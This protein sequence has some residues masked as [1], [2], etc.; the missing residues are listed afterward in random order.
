MLFDRFYMTEQCSC[1]RLSHELNKKMA[2]ISRAVRVL[3]PVAHRLSRSFD[4]AVFYEK[5]VPDIPDTLLAL[6]RNYCDALG[7]TDAAFTSIL[8]QLS[9]LV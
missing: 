8:E 1:S 3:H 7:A 5:A 6:A 2:E 4:K 9:S